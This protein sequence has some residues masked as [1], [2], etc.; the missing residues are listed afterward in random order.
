[1]FNKLGTAT[2]A[3]FNLLVSALWITLISETL[4]SSVL[5]KLP[6]NTVKVVL[7]LEGTWIAKYR[8]PSN[9]CIYFNFSSLFTFTLSTRNTFSTLKVTGLLNC[10]LLN[11]I[12]LSDNLFDSNMTNMFTRGDG[13]TLL[14]FF[15][16][17]IYYLISMARNKTEEEVDGNL[18]KLPSAIGLTL[19]GIGCI[20]LGS[21]FVV[22]SASYIAKALGVSERMIG[23]TIIA[24]GT[25][26]PELVT[27]VIATKKGEYD[28][29]IGNVVG[30]NILNI[31]IILIFF[32]N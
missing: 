17:F 15:L 18:M 26:L 5:L 22:D 8:S 4:C 27:S 6:S 12:V 13:V 9:C 20:V 28:I 30:S 2:N 14:L 7:R 11:F 29:A 31:F 1:M 10:E 23:L 32:A 25:S 24:L 21:N 19:I 16:V 3:L